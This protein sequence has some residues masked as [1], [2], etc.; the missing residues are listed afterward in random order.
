MTKK[1]DLADLLR[2]EAQKSSEI[3]TELIAAAADIEK[4]TTESEEPSETPSSVQAI[5]NSR[6]KRPGSPTKADLEIK[7]T[8]LQAALQA[9]REKEDSLQQ[10]M[11]DLQADLHEE[12]KL[13]QKLLA[14]MK[15]NND[16]KTE[17]E[18]AKKVILQL[19]EINSKPIQKVSIPQKEKEVVNT[20]EKEVSIAKVE[21]ENESIRI[22]RA[23][24]KQIPYHSIQ[25]T[26]PDT[27]LSNADIGWVD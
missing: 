17:L 4:E 9:A 14:E 6:A 8:Q 15:Q 5:A 3:E 18:Q 22:Q 21:K 16:L 19:S 13:V 25:H 23:D 20:P 2:E 7:V 26:T 12:K 24:L 1:R 10:Q 27:K 11:A